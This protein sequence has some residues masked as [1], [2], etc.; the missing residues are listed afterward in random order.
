MNAAKFVDQ[1]KV[2]PFAR[3]I[4]FTN[5]NIENNRNDAAVLDKQAWRKMDFTVLPVVTMIYFLSFLVSSL[6]SFLNRLD[7]HL[8]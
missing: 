7:K 8:C 3:N 5:I 6:S 1:K 4:S 2:S